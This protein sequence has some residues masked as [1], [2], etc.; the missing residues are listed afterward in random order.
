MVDRL[1]RLRHH[2]VIGRDDDDRDIRRLGT[3]STH[4]GERLVTRGIDEG[5]RAVDTVD[6]GGHLVRTDVLGDTAGL[7]LSDL[8]GADAVEQTRLTVVDVTHDG[9][10]GRATLEIFLAALVL[11]EREI[12]RLEQLAVLVLGTDDLDLVAHL[13][14]EELQ[15]LRG[16]RLS[17]GDHLPQVE[18]R[19]D[20]L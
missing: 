8:G 7:G 15:R 12:E 14:A 17:G 5:D 13:L 3:T 6:F 1:D 10:D 20:E 11:T 4:G 18:Q 16:H 19:L 2:A 9:H